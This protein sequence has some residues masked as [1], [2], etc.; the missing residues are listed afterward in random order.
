MGQRLRLANIEDE[1]SIDSR[2]DD[3]MSCVFLLVFYITSLRLVYLIL[4]V[5]NKNDCLETFAEQN[6]AAMSIPQSAIADIKS[7]FLP[8]NPL[9]NELSIFLIPHFIL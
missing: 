7:F 6:S 9:A 3:S 4:D 5:S 2:S 1:K 8:N